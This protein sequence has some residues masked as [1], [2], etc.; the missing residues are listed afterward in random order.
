MSAGLKHRIA[1]LEAQRSV[2]R[3]GLVLTLKDGSERTIAGT[4]RQFFRLVK[5]M[6]CEEEEDIETADILFP[7]KQLALAKADLCDIERATA[8]EGES[9]QMFGLLAALAKGPME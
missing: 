9:A 8:M 7:G 5:L 1:E 4:A 2:L 6:M 3:S